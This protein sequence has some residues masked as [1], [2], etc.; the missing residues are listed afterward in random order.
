MRNLQQI[1]ILTLSILLVLTSLSNAWGQGKKGKLSNKHKN[2]NKG[3]KVTLKS[4]PPPHSLIVNDTQ[5]KNGNFV[6]VKIFWKKEGEVFN[7][8]YLLFVK[9]DNSVNE[10]V[11]QLD[12]INNINNHNMDNEFFS[13][14]A[15]KKNIKNNTS[16]QINKV[17]VGIFNT[18]NKVKK[19]AIILKEKKNT[20]KTS[21]NIEQNIFF[22]KTEKTINSSLEEKF[23]K[24]KIK[25]IITPTDQSSPPTLAHTF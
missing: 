4:N 8:K 25:I 13:K 15:L 22:D 7:H 9:N 5:T 17:S 6:S 1:N 10:L 21:V 16:R 18:L 23:D 24:L 19:E 2:R 11:V 14:K 3:L 20:Y 12:S